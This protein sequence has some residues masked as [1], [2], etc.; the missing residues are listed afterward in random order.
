MAGYNANKVTAE[1]FQKRRNMINDKMKDPVQKE[2][3]LKALD[4]AEAKMLGT[5]TDRAD[6]VFDAKSLK[7]NPDYISESA[8]L[9]IN[10]MINEDKEEDEG[11]IDPNTLRYIT[12]KKAAA[13]AETENAG[14]TG[15][16]T[17]TTTDTG[18][19]VPSLCS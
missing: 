7:K 19:I 5:A 6:M 18:I 9:D 16:D 13:A 8:K 1:T 14:T 17:T 12:K 4:A 10:N 3:R 2:A 15:T 11:L